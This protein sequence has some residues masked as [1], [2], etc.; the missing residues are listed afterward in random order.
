MLELVAKW[1]SVQWREEVEQWI[2]DGLHDAGIQVTGTI[3]QPKVRF[4]STQLIVP[5]SAGRYW[6][7]ENH[8]AQSFEA[9]LVALLDTLVPGRVISPLAIQADRG[10]LLSPDAGPTLRETGDATTSDYESILRQYGQFQ[11]D[12]SAHDA[13]ILGTGLPDLP[14]LGAL[15]YLHEQAGALN[16]LPAGDPLHLDDQTRGLIEANVGLL[17]DAVEVITAYPVPDSLEHND[18]HSANI[19]AR[20]TGAMRFFD[21]GD[22]LWSHP[23]ASLMV[24]MDVMHRAGHSQADKDR[25]RDAYLEVFSDL[26]SRRELL[27]VAVACERISSLNRFRSWVQLM[28][29]ASPQDLEH[30]GPRTVGWLARSVAEELTEPY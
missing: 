4:W 10:W 17:G 6:F 23:F 11:R 3:T 25:V 13:P 21:F 27:A 16:S 30:W 29:A 22:A 15:D 24:P 2:T 9:S 28:D 8:P 19:F 7:K 12:L 18:L 1:S 5:T 20:G 26:H 14:A